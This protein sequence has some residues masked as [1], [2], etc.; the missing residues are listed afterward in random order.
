MLDLIPCET[1]FEE[2][3]FRV[4]AEFRRSR[5]NRTRTGFELNGGTD[6]LASL[7]GRVVVFHDVFVRDDLG[8][9]GDLFVVLDRRAGDARP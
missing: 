8:I 6:D 7:P 3:F 1:K 2:Y 9:R 5:A 4:L